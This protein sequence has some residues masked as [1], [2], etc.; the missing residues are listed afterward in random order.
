METQ[1]AATLEDPEA[2]EEAALRESLKAAEEKVKAAKASGDGLGLVDGGFSLEW[3]VEDF[4]GGCGAIIQ[5]KHEFDQTHGHILWKHDHSN[6]EC[7]CLYFLVGP[8]KL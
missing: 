3:L 5:I 6:Q 2:A 8:A 7:I 4:S 1:G